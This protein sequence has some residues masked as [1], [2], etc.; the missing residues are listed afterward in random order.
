MQEVFHY[1]R[2]HLLV[3]ISHSPVGENFIVSFYGPMRELPVLLEHIR[4][5]RLHL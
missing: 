2:E 4:E 5:L 3:F 1:T